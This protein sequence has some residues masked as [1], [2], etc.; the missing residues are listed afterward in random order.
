MCPTAPLLRHWQ[1]P[2]DRVADK[3][4]D[5]KLKRT[6]TPRRNVSSDFDPSSITAS[7]NEQGKVE[8]EE[9]V[10]TRVDNIKAEQSAKRQLNAVS[11]KYVIY[12]V[13]NT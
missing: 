6:F 7:E 3:R 2:R 10:V 1:A 9:V 12:G 4:E 13:V 11:C 8:P 5:I